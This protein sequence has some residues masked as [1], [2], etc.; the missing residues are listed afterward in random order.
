MSDATFTMQCM[1]C[2]RW[3][4]AEDDEIGPCMIKHA[5]GDIRHLTHGSH[6]C[7]EPEN[8][9]QY[10]ARTASGG[11]SDGDADHEPPAA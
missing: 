8:L 5:R 1:D 6:A 4:G 3:Y 11:D 2:T 10:A 7:D 9:A